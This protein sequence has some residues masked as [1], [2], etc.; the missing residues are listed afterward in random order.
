[1]N[2]AKLKTW[3]KKK[4]CFLKQ[5]MPCAVG[6]PAQSVKYGSPLPFFYLRKIEDSSEFGFISG[7]RP[8]LLLR[9]LYVLA[10]TP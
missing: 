10:I 6:H 8:R 7:F 5:C 2:K 1:M 4:K 3:R 9:N